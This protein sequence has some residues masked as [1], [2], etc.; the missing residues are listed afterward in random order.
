MAKEHVQ[1]ELVEDGA[2]R[3]GGGRRFRT[4]EEREEVVQRFERS[5]LMQREFAQRE[6]VEVPTLAYWR[7][8]RVRRTSGSPGVRFQELS[9]P[10]TAGFEAVLP[11]GT[12]LRAPGAEGLAQLVRLLRS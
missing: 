5:R 8:S 9:M 3:G 6:G 11:C 1:A 12:V 10:A 4:L 7:L 2:R